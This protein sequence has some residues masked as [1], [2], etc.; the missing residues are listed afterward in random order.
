[1]VEPADVVLI[2]GQ[3]HH[4]HQAGDEAGVDQPEHRQDDLVVV[5]ANSETASLAHL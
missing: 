4:D 2:A 5:R 3:H 1:M